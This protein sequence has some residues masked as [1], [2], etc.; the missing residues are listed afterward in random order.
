MH[1]APSRR[2]ESSLHH[3]LKYNFPAGQ[4]Y[5]ESGGRA[6]LK[7]ARARSMT[8]SATDIMQEIIY[9]A[10]VDS[11][12]ALRT[13]SKGVPNALLRDINAIHPNTTFADLPQDL[14]AAI[15]ASVRAAFTRLLR[16]GYSVSPANTA[17]RTAPLR[18][19]G[20]SPERRPRPPGPRPSGSRRDRPGGGKGPAGS[21]GRPGPK[22]PRGS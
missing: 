5:P 20:P 21:A 22:K 6:R 12:L 10:V 16:E 18:R 9:S 11:L 2:L 17:G 7:R 19:D 14:Q 15:G 1:F 8:K 4:I 3:K 13:A